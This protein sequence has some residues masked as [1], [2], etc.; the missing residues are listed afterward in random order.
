MNSRP[1]SGAACNK[2][3]SMCSCAAS[4]LGSSV[5]LSTRALRCSRSP[6][7]RRSRRLY[8]ATRKQGWRPSLADT[9]VIA[10]STGT[11]PSVAIRSSSSHQLPS[12][13]ARASSAALISS[14]VHC[15]STN[16]IASRVLPIAWAIRR[17]ESSASCCAVTSLRVPSTRLARPLA[18]RSS[19][20]PRTCNQRSRPPS[21]ASATRNDKSISAWAPR[22]C[23]RQ[24][25][26][27][28]GA[29]SG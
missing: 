22:R 27:R 11:A 10:T 3:L 25:R 18:S 9:E 7:W 1:N 19:A 24:A 2:A 6:F 26:R 12:D 17:S 23:K 16:A 5:G 8:G 29:S 4:R 15:A 13:W 20:R 21:K 28:A 14:T